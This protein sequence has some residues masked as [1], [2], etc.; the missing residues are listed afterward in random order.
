MNEIAL[1]RRRSFILRV[2]S[3]IKFEIYFLAALARPEQ[4]TVYWIIFS[5]KMLLIRLALRLSFVQRER[6]LIDVSVC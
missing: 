4:A 3:R 5:L 1:S 6:V 2:R